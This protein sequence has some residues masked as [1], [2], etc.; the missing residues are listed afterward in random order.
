[1]IA[2]YSGKQAN[3]YVKHFNF[4]GRGDLEPCLNHL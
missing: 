2:S 4:Y 1:M 3:Y